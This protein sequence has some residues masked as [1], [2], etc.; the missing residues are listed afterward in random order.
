MIATKC[1]TFF[2][3]KTKLLP[4]SLDKLTKRMEEID[5]SVKDYG[6]QSAPVPWSNM[7]ESGSDMWKLDEDEEDDDDEENLY[8]KNDGK[9]KDFTLFQNL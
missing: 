3:V 7:N 1:E 9:E 5:K 4:K 2:E 6:T 8:K